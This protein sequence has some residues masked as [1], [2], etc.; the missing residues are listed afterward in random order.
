MSA[1]DDARKSAD[2]RIDELLADRATQ[3]LSSAEEGALAGWLA[4]HAH[5]DAEAFER[6]AAAVDLALSAR[7]AADREA[8]PAHV[9]AK[10]L[11]SAPTRAAR[12]S[13][14]PRS[15]LVLYSGWIAAAAAVIVA[16]LAWRSGGERGA[17][18]RSIEETKALV[19]RAGDALHV[20]WKPTDD[21]DG[22]AVRGEVVW[23]PTAQ[24]G[25][26]R[27]EGLPINDPH[28]RQYQLWIF[29]AQRDDRYPIDGGVFDVAAGE[30]LVPIAARLHVADAKLF[31]VTVE[32]PGGVVVSGREHLVAL[33][34][35]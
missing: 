28:A 32:R 11:A 31:A 8:L 34:S 4:E 19:E 35:L 30:V 33:A 23:S 16:V 12:A 21:P 25:Y 18:S 14:S 13:T 1:R 27:L 2:Q 9:R 6:A 20:P 22:R 5:V 26:L 3:G 29:D 17:P 7:S 24:A 10:V 15:R